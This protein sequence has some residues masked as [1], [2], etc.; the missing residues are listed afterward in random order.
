MMQKLKLLT[1][2]IKNGYTLFEY[3]VNHAQSTPIS[4]KELDTI[5]KALASSDADSVGYISAVLRGYIKETRVSIEQL[6]K[7]VEIINTNS[8]MIEH[9]HKAYYLEKESIKEEV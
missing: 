9:F 7:L 8:S 4:D 2:N 6:R 3:R 5:Q 1:N